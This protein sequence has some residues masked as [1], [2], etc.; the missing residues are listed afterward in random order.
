LLHRWQ[1]GAI[2]AC[3]KSRLSEEEEEE[4]EAKE[5][6]EEEEEHTAWA[7]WRGHGALTAAALRGLP[8]KARGTGKVR[9]AHSAHAARHCTPG[10]SRKRG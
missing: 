1:T 4:E 6:E 8:Q 3:E 5:E 2:T 9:T 10:K 7:R